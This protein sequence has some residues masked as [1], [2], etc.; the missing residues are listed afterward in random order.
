VE[1]LIFGAFGR[2]IE[3]ELVSGDAYRI[4]NMEHGRL[5]ALADG[6]GHGAAAAEA[7]QKALSIIDG[8]VIG[9]ESEVDLMDLL[10]LC[11]AG[12]VGTRG[13]VMGL[14]HLNLKD[15]IWSSLVV[16][17]I[18]L[19]VL[20]HRRLNPIPGGGIVGYK[21]PKVVHIAEWPYCE[22]DIFISHTDGVKEDYGMDSLARDQ[23]LSVEQA[24]ERI[25]EKYGAKT[26]DAT[27]IVGR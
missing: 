11:H 10:R 2:P 4:R 6:L 22:G 3:G 19:R 12:L 8:Y 18:T 7:S 1:G 9:H 25:I 27:V 17:N 14:C 20:S 16:G 15:R 5:I 23:G 26:D 24:A 21:L 13:A